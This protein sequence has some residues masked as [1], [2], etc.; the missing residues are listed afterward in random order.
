MLQRL[1]KNHTTKYF[2]QILPISAHKNSRL[3]PLCYPKSHNALLFSTMN[4]TLVFMLAE[5][6]LK[7]TNA[8]IISDSKSAIEKFFVISFLYNRRNMK[9]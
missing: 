5:A 3:Q 9:Q 6:I 2:H 8:K 4:K 1:H 7:K